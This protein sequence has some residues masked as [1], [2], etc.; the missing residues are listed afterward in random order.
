MGFD[1]TGLN[2]KNLHLKEPDRP[3]NLWELSKEKQNEYFDLRD[4]YT[5][6][7]GTYFRNNVWWWRP[8]AHYVLEYTKVIPEDRKEVWSYNDNSEVSQKEAEMIAQQL[9]YLIDSGHTKKFSRDWEA[10]RKKLE[11]HNDKVEK[12]LEKHTKQ[13]QTKMKNSNLAPKDFPEADKKIWDKIYHK[14]NSD[15]SYPFSIENVEEFAE[16][17]ENCGGF[18]IG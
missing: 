1:I 4:K 3:D 13:V 7:S 16:F 8:L 5:S 12:E 14:R 6:Q 18:S 17:C 10:R 11:K 2:P 9:R 15:A